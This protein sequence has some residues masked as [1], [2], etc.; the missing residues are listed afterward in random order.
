[1]SS[2]RRETLVRLGHVGRP[3]GLRGAFYLV[4]RRELLPKEGVDLSFS[5]SSCSEHWVTVASQKLTPRGLLLTCRELSRREEI[6]ALSGRE[7]WISRRD[8]DVD[9]S[10]EYLWADL[11][12]KTVLDGQEQTV[13][14]VVKVH[15]FGASDIVE[16]VSETKG[17]LLL[18]FVGDY[19]DFSFSH[20]DRHLRM[21][22][23]I[24]WFSDV[25]E[26]VT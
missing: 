24:D 9:D 18:P 20:H 11:V 10:S 22:V 8:L 1:M 5:E 16:I 4:G 15:N 3:K 12:G 2:C 23:N 14:S 21:L 13:G 17:K 6:E 19:F 25:W 26:A 7:V